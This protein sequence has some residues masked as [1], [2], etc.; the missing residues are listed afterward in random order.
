MKYPFHFPWLSISLLILSVG[1][2]TPA[3]Q[4]EDGNSQTSSAV[5]VLD[6]P[7]TDAKIK[8]LGEPLQVQY[9]FKTHKKSESYDVYIAHSAV[10][11]TNDGLVFIQPSGEFINAP[12]PYYTKIS[13]DTEEIVL[14]FTLPTDDLTLIGEHFFYAAL[15]K[16]GTDVSGL[17]P[18]DWPWEKISTDSVFVSR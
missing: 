3:T 9:T 13:S 12:L 18:A 1:W 6:N 10:N 8:R 16:T 15:L 17:A 7:L 5:E 2:I 11:S 14:D 4:A